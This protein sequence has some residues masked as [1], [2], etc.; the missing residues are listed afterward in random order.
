[1]VECTG[2]T[3][4]SQAIATCPSFSR[5]G[6]EARARHHDERRRPGGHD[7]R[8]LVL[9]RWEGPH[10]RPALRRLHRR[11]RRGRRVTGATSSRVRR[12]SPR[13]VPERRWADRAARPAR[14]S[15]ARTSPRPT[16]IR[17]RP[18]ARSRSARRPSEFRFAS[19][20]EFEEHHVL[21]HPGGRKREPELHLL[22]GLLGRRR[23]RAGARRPGPVP[24]SFDRDRLARERDDGLHP[25]GHRCP[26]STSAGSGI[27][28]LVVGGQSVPVGPTGLWTA[29]VPLS[30]GTNTITALATDGAGATAQ[31]QIAVVYTPPPPA[32]H[33]DRR[34]RRLGARFRRP[35]G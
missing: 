10:A 21:V 16:G 1:M 23:H 25:D 34:R 35:R 6:R 7:D 12:A 31:A 27:T 18:S 22:R 29:Q 11:A 30:P 8:H 5:L 19:N 17:T 28:S 24:G 4:T 9:D 32:P 15:C 13:T 2:R 26:V 14:S 20:N 3:P 33:A